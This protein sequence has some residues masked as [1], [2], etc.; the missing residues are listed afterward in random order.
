MIQEEE[1][2]VY[3]ETANLLSGWEKRMFMARVVRLLG[4]GGQRLAER[5]LGWNRGTIR[6]GLRELEKGKPETKKGKRGRKPV[7]T[8]LPTLMTDIKSA[9]DCLCAKDAVFQQ[10]KYYTSV[11]VRQLRSTLIK[12]KNYSDEELPTNETLRIRINQLGFRL[13]RY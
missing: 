9:M 8:L 2:Q 6:K 7:E 13:K 12:H 1:R 4:Q 5:E 11:T 10:T 3:I